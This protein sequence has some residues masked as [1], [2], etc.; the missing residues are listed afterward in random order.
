MFFLQKNIFE[1]LW[2]IQIILLVFEDALRYY[3][4]DKYKLICHL[5]VNTWVHHYD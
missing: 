5:D 3:I 2:F 1:N 4:L